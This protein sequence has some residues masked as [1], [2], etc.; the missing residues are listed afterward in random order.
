MEKEPL[1]SIGIMQNPAE[2]IPFSPELSTIEDQSESSDY[3]SAMVDVS[4][5]TRFVNYEH[6]KAK[7]F[8]KSSS[9]GLFRAVMDAK[10]QHWAGFKSIPNVSIGTF[11]SRRR[12]FWE[13]DPV[14]MDKL[15]YVNRH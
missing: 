1:G 9:V 6:E 14:C 5:E 2:P 7:Y 11:A 4:H 12:Q 8:G 15:K 3:E 13:P 10:Q